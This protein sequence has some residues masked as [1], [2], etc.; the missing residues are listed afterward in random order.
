MSL[1]WKW[2]YSHTALEAKLT[3]ND[4]L[5]ELKSTLEQISL[6]S[7]HCREKEIKSGVDHCVK[8]CNVLQ[9]Q[10][11]D[12]KQQLTERIQ[13]LEGELEKHHQLCSKFISLL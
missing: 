11:D 6:Q 7:Q 5:A 3:V 13:Q 8:M 10:L 2:T 1:R 12:E 4:R 9:K